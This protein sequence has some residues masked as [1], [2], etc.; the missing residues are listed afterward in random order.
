MQLRICI[1]WGPST[2]DSRIGWATHRRKTTKPT[3]EGRSNAQKRPAL[4]FSIE[5][6]LPALNLWLGDTS[7]IQRR[8]VHPSPRSFLSGH[9]LYHSLPFSF[10]L[11][12]SFLSLYL[13]IYIYPY[14]YIYGTIIVLHLYRV[15]DLGTHFK[16]GLE[17]ILGAFQLVSSQHGKVNQ[18]GRTK[19]DVVAQDNWI[20]TA[21]GNEYLSLYSS[22]FGGSWRQRLMLL[23]KTSQLRKERLW[24]EWTRRWW[25]R[26]C[27]MRQ[28]SGGIR[29]DDHEGF[30]L[31]PPAGGPAVGAR[32]VG[33]WGLGVG[34]WVGGGLGGWALW[35]PSGPLYRSRVMCLW[36]TVRVGT[37]YHKR[38]AFVLVQWGPGFPLGPFGRVF[39]CSG[40]GWYFSIP[41]IA[42]SIFLERTT[43]PYKS[44]CS[45][46][47]FC[48]W[49]GPTPATFAA[50]RCG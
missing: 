42:R 50:E 4:P 43:R 22:V 2:P 11:S 37:V 40:A 47:A 26:S 48:V 20:G 5:S 6:A 32:G 25:R 31:G 46:G 7:V 36:Q 19:N 29:L 41:K 30:G 33:G 17:C 24:I 8:K 44:Y 28:S 45:I 14:V 35:V 12:V 9:F 39:V 23:T 49:G 18:N 1:P 34:G 16:P 15:T 10:S 27:V 3:P 13:C 21:Q 38:I